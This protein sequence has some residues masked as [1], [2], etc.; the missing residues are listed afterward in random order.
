MTNNLYK[1]YNNKTSMLEEYSKPKLLAL[2]GMPIL[3]IILILLLTGS[4]DCEFDQ[5][6]F[7]AKANA[8]EKAS[9]KENVEG[10]IAEYKTNN[11]ILTKEII[12]F[13]ENEPEQVKDFFKNKKMTCEH[14]KNNF[15]ITL[16][17]GVSTNIN[18]CEGELKNAIIELRLAQIQLE[19]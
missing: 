2:I 16:I 4:K 1:P 3:F 12:E 14:I 19:S 15:D 5:T 8:C 7:I 13:S 9:L 6:C 17:Q 10:S 18:D 11:C